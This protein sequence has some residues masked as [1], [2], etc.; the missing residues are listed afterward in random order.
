MLN[1]E[2][3]MDYRR[4]NVN[5]T[6]IP[7]ETAGWNGRSAQGGEF[8]EHFS[9]VIDRAADAG[10]RA[11]VKE[12]HSAEEDPQSVMDRLSGNHRELGKVIEET[13][14]EERKLS[15]EEL[16]QV[17]SEHREKV[18]KKLKNG[19]TGVKIPIG[20]MSLTEEE[21]EKLLE[22]FDDAQEKIQE[23]IRKENGEDL[24]EKRPDTTVNGDKLF[25]GED[26][27]HDVKSLEELAVE[28]GIQ[29][30]V[31][32]EQEGD[33]PVSLVKDGSA[34]DRSGI[35]SKSK[36]GDQHENYIN[37]DRQRIAGGWNVSDGELPGELFKRK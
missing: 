9:R 10:G 17:I 4:G 8:S 16:L 25:A 27:G 36:N 35:D 13:A 34:G 37:Y 33:F 24:P 18:L 12:T 14:K 30:E 3:S 11:K 7:Q 21:W 26:T 23:T 31:V 15:R 6:G 32:A 2:N 19:D 20:S 29:G 28:A 22:N 1:T 5:R